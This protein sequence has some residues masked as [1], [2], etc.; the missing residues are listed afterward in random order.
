MVASFSFGSFSNQL[1]L[2]II[3][4]LTLLL[5]SWTSSKYWHKLLLK[6]KKG[7]RY[8]L[9]I[10][11]ESYKINVLK[12]QEQWCAS[13]MFYKWE[14]YMPYKECCFYVTR[15]S[16]LDILTWNKTINL[17]FFSCVC[18][19]DAAASPPNPTQFEQLC[20]TIEHITCNIHLA[21]ARQPALTRAH[22]CTHAHQTY[23][24]L[25]N[26]YHVGH[27]IWRNEILVTYLSI[28]LFTCCYLTKSNNKSLSTWSTSQPL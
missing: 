25:H 14:L 15:S 1:W 24:I 13:N 21:H 28:L 9:N 18:E 19:R 7:R 27:F 26:I 16:N 3:L 11:Y 23:H 12:I 17:H 22:A 4:I 5:A 2:L 8:G 6:E 20:S 10:R